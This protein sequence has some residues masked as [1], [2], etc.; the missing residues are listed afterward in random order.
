MAPSSGVPFGHQTGLDKRLA[1]LDQPGAGPLE[2]D[3]EFFR[4]LVA[5][6]LG[7]EPTEIGYRNRSGRDQL[8]RA[9]YDPI[10]FPIVDRQ[11][12]LA[13]G[14][15]NEIGVE[16]LCL[17][18]D[19]SADPFSLPLHNASRQWPVELNL[20][21]AG[22]LPWADTVVDSP[23]ASPAC[24]GAGGDAARNSPGSAPNG[25]DGQLGARIGARVF[26]I[27][28]R[29][30]LRC[31]ILGATPTT[32]SPIGAGPVAQRPFD[33]HACARFGGAAPPVR[34]QAGK[35]SGASPWLRLRVLV[36]VVA[37]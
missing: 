13:V 32:G 12:S 10:A 36:F 18:D 7:A 6:G 1:V 9:G 14:A 23:Q 15:Y 22:W 26:G 3:V 25:G 20:T 28:H 34:A 21:I 27:T 33:V 24:A 5:T 35:A 11:L 31:A 19:K 37:F 2:P 8:L 30:A 16:V 4:I 17:G 29:D